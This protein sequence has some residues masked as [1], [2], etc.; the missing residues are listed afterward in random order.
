MLTLLILVK[1]NYKNMYS[2]SNLQNKRNRGILKFP[3]FNLDRNYPHFSGL[4]DGGQSRLP[5]I[6]DWRE[7]ATLIM[8]DNC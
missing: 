4:H 6:F 7:S 5:D 3:Y 2:F 8:I 1:K